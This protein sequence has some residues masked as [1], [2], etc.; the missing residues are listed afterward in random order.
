MVILEDQNHVM[1]RS[2]PTPAFFLLLVVFFSCSG[3]QGPATAVKL[4]SYEDL[5]TLFGEWRKF[6]TPFFREGIPD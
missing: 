2:F 3:P 1:F 4:R 6:Q 5:V